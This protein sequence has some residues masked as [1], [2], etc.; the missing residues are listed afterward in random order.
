MKVQLAVT[1]QTEEFYLD[2]FWKTLTNEEGRGEVLR[3]VRA[4]LDDHCFVEPGC[5]VRLLDFVDE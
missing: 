5:R 2:E 3:A 1:I 4:C